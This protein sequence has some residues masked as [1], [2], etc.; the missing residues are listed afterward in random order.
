MSRPFLS[1]KG[2]VREGE[3]KEGVAERELAFP[4]RH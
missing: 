3:R 1:G 4:K 2:P